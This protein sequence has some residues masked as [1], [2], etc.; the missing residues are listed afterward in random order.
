VVYGAAA[1]F[2]YLKANP[3]SCLI[4]TG[5]ASG[6]Y[7][8]PGLASYS[9]TKFAVRGLTEALDIEWT[10]HQIRVKSLMPGFINT[11]LLDVTSA[12]SNRTAREDVVDAGLEFTPVETVAQAAWDAATSSKAVHHPVGKTAKQLRFMA[13]WAPG[14][15]RK[16][17]LKSE[18]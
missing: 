16:S 14:F 17:L 5:S 18:L 15:L 12:G 1:A 13:R 6:I 8:T 10:P 4:N 7:G 2:T 9:A 3:G 11:P